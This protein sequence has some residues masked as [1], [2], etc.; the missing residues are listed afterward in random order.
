MKREQIIALAEK[1]G[2]DLPHNLD[3]FWEIWPDELDR[4]VALVAAAEREECAK[5][6]DALSA[7]AGRIK[8]CIGSLEGDTGYECATALRGGDLIEPD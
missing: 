5:M 6:C 8:T 4:F 2:I 7:S 1:A 3:T